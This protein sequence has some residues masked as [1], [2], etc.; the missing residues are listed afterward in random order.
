MRQCLTLRAQ[1]RL[2]PTLLRGTRAKEVFDRFGSSVVLRFELLITYKIDI[3]LFMWPR[4]S[5][6]DFEK[7]VLA[8][9]FDQCGG[10]LRVKRQDLSVGLTSIQTVNS[11]AFGDGP[12]GLN[13]RDNF[14]LEKWE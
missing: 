13:F 3:T 8:A 11:F 12:L 1:C 10:A 2:P 9:R 7:W 6:Q 5:F 14:Y 4:I